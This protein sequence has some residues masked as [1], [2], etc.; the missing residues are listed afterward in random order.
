MRRQVP[1]LI[2]L[3]VGAVLIIAAFIPRAPFGGLGENFSLYFDII[4]VFAFLLGGGNLIRIHGM[5]LVRG[6]GMAI[7]EAKKG[8]GAWP[9]RFVIEFPFLAFGGLKDRRG[10]DW[11]FSL[12]TLLGFFAMLA[13]GLLKLGNPKGWQGNVTTPGAMFQE[14]YDSMFNPLQATMYAL[15]AFFVASA[16]YRAFRAKSVEATILLVTAFIILLGRTPAGAYVTAWMPESLSF[17]T[18]PNLA[19]WVMAIP[20]LAGQRAII[21]GIALGVIAMSLRV[22]IG[23]ERTYLGSDEK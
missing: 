6:V 7:T 21:I 17:L 10:R 5:R 15:L 4:A 12:I 22:I 3:V 19:N 14:F 8:G 16:S 9:L 2:T 20:N 18:I 11:F 23:I 1:L 13:A